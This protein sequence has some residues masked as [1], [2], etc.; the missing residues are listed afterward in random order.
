MEQKINIERFLDSTGKIMQLP[1]KQATKCE[2]LKYLASKFEE[3]CIYSERE[4]NEICN[5]WHTFGDHF[6]LRRELVDH[7]LL[8]R[9]Q[10][11]SQYWR[12]QV[13]LFRL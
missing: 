9:K 6:L 11:G 4:V 8:C 7:D 13:S 3:G 2:L 10:D 1:Q 12:A 5:E